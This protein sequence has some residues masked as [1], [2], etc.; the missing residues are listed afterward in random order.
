MFSISGCN[1]HDAYILKLGV[2]KSVEKFRAVGAGE[3]MGED[4]D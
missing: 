4:S 2:L 3:A 1:L